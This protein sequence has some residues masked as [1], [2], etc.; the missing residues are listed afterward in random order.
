MDLIFIHKSLGTINQKKVSSNPISHFN[1]EHS[2]FFFFFLSIVG[3]Q[4]V[5]L[6]NAELHQSNSR[7]C[8]E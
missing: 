3:L 6:I 4:V 2:F 1:R 5:M 8:S 7:R